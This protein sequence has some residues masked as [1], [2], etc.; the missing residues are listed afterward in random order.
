MIELQIPLR[1]AKLKKLEIGDEVLISGII[2]TARDKAHQRLVETI[3]RGE[4]IPVDLKDQVIF[5]AGPT[6]AKS[7]EGI[8]VIGPTTSSRMDPF[9]A[10]LLKQGL[11]G[12]IGKG[13]RSSEVKKAIRQYQAI[14]FVATG[15]A[16]AFLSK[17]VK[18]AEVVA[19]RNLGPEAIYR[20]EVE[21]FPVVVA[22][23]SQGGDLFAEAVRKYG[24][25]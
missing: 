11:K 8:G 16:A 23:D 15:G 9:T 6:P 3:T 2:Y 20:L 1:E 21:K 18:R 22:V 25:E 19:Y 12:M 17:I 13:D 24:R 4:E 10:T 7:G 14:Y 5:Y